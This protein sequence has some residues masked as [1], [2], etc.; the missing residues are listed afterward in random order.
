MRPL[1]TSEIAAQ[2]LRQL[3]QG[4][5]H[6]G[7]ATCC[8]MCGREILPGDLSAK[9]KPSQTFTDWLNLSPS[10]H[11]CGWCEVTT[12]QANMRPLQRAVVTPEGVYP[13]GKDDNRAWFLLTPPE[14]PYSVVVSNRSATATFHLHWRTPVTLSNNLVLVRVDDQVLRIRRQLLL[15]ALDVCQEVATLM[16][17][18]RAATMKNPGNAV[19]RHPF[20]SLDRSLADARHGRI[21]ED[22]RTAAAGR[23]ELLRVLENLAQGELWALATLA[24]ANK[25]TPTKPELITSPKQASE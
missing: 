10:E 8:A 20:S 2:A 13:I 25:P 18:H 3:P 4:T 19:A 17:A 9:F 24:K 5:P 22:A 21:R 6:V 23:P 11:L 16:H 7:A 12:V 1:Y 15:E 14:P